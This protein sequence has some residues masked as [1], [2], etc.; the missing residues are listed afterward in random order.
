ASACP[1]YAVTTLPKLRRMWSTTLS[2]NTAPPW[3]ECRESCKVNAAKCLGRPR[4]HLDDRVARRDTPGTFGIVLTG[5][6][7]R[8]RFASRDRDGF[9]RGDVAL[10]DNRRTDVRTVLHGELLTL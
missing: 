8:A 2:W 5:Q 6:D 1:S 3:S 4:V 7:A 9:P 10:D